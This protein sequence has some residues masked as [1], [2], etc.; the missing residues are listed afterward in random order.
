MVVVVV[1]VMIYSKR[2]GFKEVVKQNLVQQI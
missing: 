2:E 1:V